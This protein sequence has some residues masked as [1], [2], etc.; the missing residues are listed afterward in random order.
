MPK[1]GKQ[2]DELYLVKAYLYQGKK[3]KV[4]TLIVPNFLVSL[5]LVITEDPSKSDR[6]SLD[7]KQLLLVSIVDFHKL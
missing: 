5:L 1:Q 3:C 6:T 2:R 7:L 4:K